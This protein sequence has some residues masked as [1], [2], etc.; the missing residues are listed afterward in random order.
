MFMLSMSAQ[1]FCDC[2]EIDFE[3]EGICVLTDIDTTGLTLW[4]PDECHAACWYGEDYTVVECE[5]DWGWEDD[6]ECPTADW[7]SEGICVQVTEGDYDWTEWAPDECYA[8]CWYEEYTIVD[9]DEIDWGW[10]DECDCPAEDWESEGICVEI[11]LADIDTLGLGFDSLFVSWAPSEC[12]AACWFGEYTL[13]DCDEIDWGWEDECDCP[14]EDWENDGICIEVFYGNDTYQEWMP[15]ECYAACWY[16][17]FTVVECD[18]DWGWEDDCDCPE[19]GWNT[20]GICVEINLAE[21]DSLDFELDSIFVTW[22]PNECYAACWYNDYTVVECEDDWGWEDDCD[23]PDEDWSSEGV[24]F[25]VGEG[26]IEWAPSECYAA[27]WYDEYT[28]VDCDEIDWGG[29]DWDLEC[30]CEID[31][32]E[33]ICIAYTYGVDTL[34]EWVPNECFADCWGFEDYAVVDCEDFWDWDNDWENDWENDWDGEFEGDLDCV[35]DVFESELTTLQSFILAL[36]ECGLFE[37]TDCVLEAPIFETDEEFI[38]YLAEN[39]PEWFGELMDES[40]GPSLF[41]QYEGAQ[42]DQV[43]S[44]TEVI[45]ELDVRLL[46]NPVVD[47]LDIQ[48]NT[49]EGMNL[50][51]TLRTVTGRVINSKN[52]RLDQGSQVYSVNT[53]GMT[54]GTYLMTMAS[55]EGVQ[56]IRFVVAK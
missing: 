42:S 46:S 5:D 10:E 14:A 18:D 35:I 6:C 53:V 31:S 36:G 33:G 43:T 55:E 34:V 40:E 22:V 17:D 12:Y 25:E 11:N 56:T 9:C 50:N 24:C 54:G 41:N 48:I 44:T 29:S 19:D 3:T 37:L 52:I 20:D 32:D 23:C 21:L 47:Q 13:A 16:E 27:C 4:A 8:A 2:P 49:T 30:E 45:E 7:E 15:S 1:E 39:C 51:M 38:D 26:Y 28:L